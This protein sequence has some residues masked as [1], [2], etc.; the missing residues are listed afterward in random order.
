M[1]VSLVP[2]KLKNVKGTVSG[3]LTKVAILGTDVFFKFLR[4]P[5]RS[6]FGR[7]MAAE[8]PMLKFKNSKGTLILDLEMDFF[9]HVF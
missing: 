6:I 1:S 9:V 8:H 5:P 7:E 3:I 2:S 4:C